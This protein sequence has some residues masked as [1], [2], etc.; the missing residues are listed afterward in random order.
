[1]IR[2]INIYKSYGS[3]RVLEDVTLEIGRGE[4]LSVVGRNGS[5][6][7]TLLKIMGILAYPDKGHLII[8]NVDVTG[9]KDDRL[10][11][12]IRRKIGY[13]FQQPLLI[14]Y[15][16]VFEN[17]LLSSNL[18]RDEMIEL[19]R[20]MELYDR[21]RH[22][23]GQLSEGEKKRVDLARA[24]AKRPEILIADEP[25]SYLDPNHMEKVSKLFKNFVDE[26]G[27]LIISSTIEPN[28]SYISKFF[29]L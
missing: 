18:D 15:M 12:E 29:R 25:F 14:P 20:Y 24:F 5:G 16:N 28:L 3:I 11:I 6:K 26:G 7:T 21:L 22:R 1:M 17:V 27:T 23:P 8:D 19:L 4:C 9:K 10:L 13:S 2:L